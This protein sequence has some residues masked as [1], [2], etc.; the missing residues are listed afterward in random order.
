[1]RGLRLDPE[2]IDSV[3]FDFTLYVNDYKKS[4]ITASSN[5]ERRRA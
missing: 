1:V 4:S 3:D 5:K 2:G